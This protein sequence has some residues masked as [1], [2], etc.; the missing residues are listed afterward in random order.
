MTGAGEFD[1]GLILHEE[2]RNALRVHAV[3]LIVLGY[4]RLGTGS[5]ATAEEDDITGELVRNIRFVVADPTSPD[6]VEHY[7]IREQVPQNVSNKLGKR[8]PRIDVEIE[9]NIRGTRP[10]LSFEAKRLGRGGR[11]SDYLGTEGLGAF[12]SGHYPTTHGEA[13]MLGYL[14]ENDEEHWCSRFTKELGGGKYQLTANGAWNILDTILETPLYSSTHTDSNGK[15]LF[16]VHLL[17]KF[18][19]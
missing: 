10:C 1:N 2:Y 18:G 7:E 5:L 11:L 13:G 4:R 16:V 17:L 19:M 12:L 8:R 9:R 6:W 15:P 3:S 14:Q